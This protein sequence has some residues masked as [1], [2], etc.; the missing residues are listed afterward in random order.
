MTEQANPLPSETPEA[1]QASEPATV[2][3]G[4]FATVNGQLRELPAVSASIRMSFE[5]T[6]IVELKTLLPLELNAVTLL[7]IIQQRLSLVFQ[8]TDISTGA[9]LRSET[10]DVKDAQVQYDRPMPKSPAS[11]PSEFTETATFLVHAP[12]AG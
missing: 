3:L 5:G 7:T 2:K 12:K 9:I 8:Y 1:P 4:I 10:L 11:R 6:F